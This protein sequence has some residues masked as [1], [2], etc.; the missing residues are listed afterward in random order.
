MLIN[1]DSRADH[2]TI[3][4]CWTNC[5]DWDLPRDGIPWSSTGGFGAAK[6]QL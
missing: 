4:L 6:E 5:P 1:N 3:G 2:D